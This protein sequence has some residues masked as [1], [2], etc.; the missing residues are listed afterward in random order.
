MAIYAV[1]TLFEMNGM[2][3]V[4]MAVYAY[5]S[6]DLDRLIKKLGDMADE[7]R[8]QGGGGLVEQW[9]RPVTVVVPSLEF[10]NYIEQ[11]LS[12]ARG[13]AINVEYVTLEQL[14]TEGIE[15]AAA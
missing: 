9:S 1:G 2:D 12:R 3:E 15:Q 5:C 4:I 6:D 7:Q 14:I 11:A 10:G 13:V 8:R